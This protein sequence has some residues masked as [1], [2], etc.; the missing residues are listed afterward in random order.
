MRY[1]E[2]P[3]CRLIVAS[4]VKLFL[5]VFIFYFLRLFK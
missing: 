3:I 2:F 4:K 1:F 5:V